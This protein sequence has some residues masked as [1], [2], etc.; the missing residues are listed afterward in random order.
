MKPGKYRPLAC[1]SVLDLSGRALFIQDI[2]SAI[3]DGVTHP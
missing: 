1:L 3:L 2:E